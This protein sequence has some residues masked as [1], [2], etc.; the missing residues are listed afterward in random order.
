MFPLLIESVL[1]LL[2]GVTI[3]IGGYHFI[4]AKSIAHET[5]IKQNKKRA[6]NMAIVKLH[7][8]DSTDIMNF[9]NDNA[10]YLSEDMVEKLADHLETVKIINEEPLKQRFEDLKTHQRVDGSC[11]NCG[12]IAPTGHDMCITCDS[13]NNF[14]NENNTNKL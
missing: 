3:I 14:Q 10:Q 4:F 13:I 9:L 11:I 7:S 1:E 6:A 2:V 8:N 12:S 5:A